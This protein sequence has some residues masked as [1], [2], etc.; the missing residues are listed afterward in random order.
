MSCNICCNDY[1]K[2]VRTKI[3]CNYCEFD[4]CRTCCE[5]YILS[6]TTPKCMQPNCAKDWSRKFLRDNLTYTFLNTKYKNHL[7]NVLFEQEKALMPATQPLAERV[8]YRNKIQAKITEI[9]DEILE[10]SKKRAKLEKNLHTFNHSN[11]S[12][13]KEGDEAN[14]TNRF[15]R[16][17]PA[18][19]CR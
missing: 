14:K 9:N 2:S 4:V 12:T 10:L 15:V 1:N 17:C 13:K 5:T 7:E 11:G 8:L 18:A 6:E 19:V 3:V 16:Q